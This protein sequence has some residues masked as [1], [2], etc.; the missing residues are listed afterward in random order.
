MNTEKQRLHLE[1]VLVLD[2]THALAGPL[3]TQR[4]AEMGA[5]VIKVESIHGGDFSR[6]VL[7]GELQDFG[8]SIAF[9]AM[10]RNK[11]SISINLKDP[12]GLKIFYELV[13]KA[14]VLVQNYRYGVVERLKIAYSDLCKIN[15][16]LVY[17]SITG[18][19]ES[20]TM[21]DRPGQDLLLQSFCGLTMNGGSRNSVPAP[22]PTF[23]VDVAA[24]HLAT[25]AV[26]AGL[27]KSL[28]TG[29][30]SNASISMIG[31]IMEVQLQEIT[32]YLA[33]PNPPNRIQY[34]SATVWMDPPYGIHRTKKGYLALAQCDLVLLS[35]LLHSDTLKNIVS[36]KPAFKD[37]EQYEEWRDDI[38]EELENI[39]QQKTA[40]EWDEYLNKNKVWSMRVMDYEE[41]LNHEQTQDYLVTMEHYKY[42]KYRTVKP[43][44]T[45]KETRE[46]ELVSAPQYAEHTKEVLLKK[47][48][49]RERIEQL[50][51]KNVIY[52][53]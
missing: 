24:S 17:V 19:G 21:V 50:I 40:E 46:Q 49:S 39:F 37:N 29:E 42:G 51:E 38:Y 32:A 1:G 7:I 25:E 31:A 11:K 12:E 18:Y 5:E 43:A 4:L 33:H 26:L 48:F 41:F 6:G 28:L 2:L 36:K 3:A 16:K 34:D 27:Y 22:S 30:G 13:E 53:N 10:N 9:V 8:D 52:Q 15:K 20:G 47:G 23:I 35:E 45:F 44:I 14:D